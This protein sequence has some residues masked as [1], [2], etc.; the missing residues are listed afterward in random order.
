MSNFNLISPEG[1]GFNF[2]VRFDEPIIVPENASVH[3]NWCQFERDNK[4]VFLNP[5]TIKLK[6]IDVLPYFDWN[7]DENGKVSGN[8][9]INGLERN[10]GD[11]TF[12]IPQGKYTVAELQT[13]IVKAFTQVNKGICGNTTEDREGI[14]ELTIIAD[15]P[16]LK[17]N[18][19]KLICPMFEPDPTH[20]EMGVML[21]PKP[22]GAI[23]DTTNNKG[24]TYDNDPS[25]GY[26]GF[27]R[28]E[29]PTPDGT[30][31]LGLPDID[32]YNVYWMGKH[33]YIHTGGHF[34]QY[35]ANHLNNGNILKSGGFDELQ[36]L[37]TINFRSN[38]EY[39]DT[40]GSVFVGLYVK[41][42]AGA[43]GDAS[44][45]GSLTDDPLANRIQGGNMIAKRD[46]LNSGGYYPKCHFGV[47]YTGYDISV[48]TDD[49]AEKLNIIH[50]ELDGGLNAT[51][52]SKILGMTRTY[53]ID[54]TK[55]RDPNDDT[56]FAFGIQTY[57]DKGNSNKI[58]TGADKGDLHIRVYIQNAD[59]TSIVVYD[60]NTKYPHQDV[61]QLQSFSKAFMNT[62]NA[63]TEAN[64]QPDTIN[65]AQA[66]SSIPFVPIVSATKRLEGGTI[67][68]SYFQ[69]TTEDDGLER[70]NSL[71]LDYQLECS[72]E[73]GN[74]F[75]PLGQN[76]SFTSPIISASYIDYNGAT[77]FVNNEIASIF[78]ATLGQNEFYFRENNILGQYRQDKFSVVLN[79][80][81]IKSYKNTND[82]TKSGYRKPILA[83]IPNP[84]A[85]A[86]ISMGNTG[87][88][89]GSYQSSLG[90][91]NRLSN[92]AITTN[93][94]DVL[95]LD[96]ETDKP[97]EQ[98][99][100]TIVN[101]T[102]TAD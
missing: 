37:N 81:P 62:Y 24:M 54:I 102:I 86:D 73:L 41:G 47:E 12:T 43:D 9:L 27:T 36:N 30:F 31:T 44:V 53:S 48:I 96:L 61:G 57:Y 70:T 39:S 93:N 3:M 10:V 45:I 94:F 4:I 95:I 20:L 2:N 58:F 52:E 63:S 33:R 50:A 25:D 15:N 19:Y 60:T 16:S 98:L 78:S 97:A 1:N 28:K 67:K 101:F 46:T 80:L 56:P 21:N 89:L 14:N 64:L 42:Y 38:T 59:G 92:Q 82:K 88:I 8:Y 71:L 5:Q 68:Y 99:T 26:S 83:N 13:E 17:L 66:Q 90:I 74:L 6:N 72:N 35:I 87:K 79:N 11:L 18:A 55:Y 100:K 65:L 23:P 75:Q 91:V 69:E 34:Q 84:F 32:A 49:E 40:K 29:N 76:S 85:G 7:N 51:M 22:L 77:N